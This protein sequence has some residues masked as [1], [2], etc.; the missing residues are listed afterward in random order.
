MMN[1]LTLICSLLLLLTFGFAGSALA[2]G[3]KELDTEKIAIK[4][5]AEVTRGGYQ[6]VST[7][8]L[9]QW[10][11]KGTKMLI[12]DTM[13]YEASYKKAHIPGAVQMEFP[14][15]EVTELD[16]GKQDKLNNR[17]FRQ[18]KVE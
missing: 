12:V 7:E 3:V 10:M 6:V 8:E 15:P 9:K 1:K 18:V 4:F 11:D 17:I 14:I 2:F 13:P 5:N 16:A